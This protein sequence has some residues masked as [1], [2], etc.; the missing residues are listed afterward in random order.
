[1][2]GT[3]CIDSSH[4]VCLKFT[5]NTLI[6]FSVPPGEDTGSK[7]PN[8]SSANDTSYDDSPTTSV[9]SLNMIAIPARTFENV[10][11]DRTGVVFSLY[12]TSILF[13]LRLTQSEND[14]YKTIG[15]PVI[16]ATVA[17]QMVMGLTELVNITLSVT[18][19]VSQCVLA[20]AQL[21]RER[22]KE[23]R[24]VECAENC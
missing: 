18:A 19:T 24:G 4:N 22:K 23:Q 11:N 16:S 9:S 12:S 7:S 17:G 8:S 20:H 2:Y 5:S 3:Y 1:M 21:C 14:T 6:Q 15:S 13:P 10:T